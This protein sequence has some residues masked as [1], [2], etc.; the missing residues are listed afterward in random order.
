MEHDVLP[1]DPGAE[2]AIVAACVAQPKDSKLDHV[3]GSVQPADFFDIG[4]RLVFSAIVDLHANKLAVDLV[5]IHGWLSRRG[6][7]GQVDYDDF[8]TGLSNHPWVRDVAPHV[9]QVCRL[10]RLRRLIETCQRLAAEGRSATENAEE[11]IAHA[12]SAIY[13]STATAESGKIVYTLKESAISLYERVSLELKARQD[14]TSV[15]TDTGIIGLDNIIGPLRPGQLVV[16]AARPSLGK[17][18]LMLNISAW[19]AQHGIGAHV[20]SLETNR[21]NIAGRVIAANGELSISSVMSGKLGND[22]QARLVSAIGRITKLPITIDDRS[23][24]N[25]PQIR[26][27]IRR[28]AAE[29]KRT[30]ANGNVTQKLGLV[31][32]DYLQLAHAQVGRGNREQEVSAVAYGLL[33]LAGEFGV[34]II[35]L[36]QLNRAVEGRKDRRPLMSDIRESGAIEQAASIIIALYR[37]NE[38][39]R[40]QSEENV[41]AIVLKSKDSAVGATKLIFKPEWMQFTQDTNNEFE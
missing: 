20:I 4:C 34:P 13:E 22:E 5:A 1:F 37:E 30:D 25:I 3:V 24:L 35:A 40:G 23:G 32:L 29:L 8:K 12:E 11:F 16:I 18:A 31:C 15:T 9:A 10:A 17:T 21:E 19:V 2:W 6:V 41:E 14:G 27:S 39:K 26:A 28:A 7:I 36:S 38:E 33:E